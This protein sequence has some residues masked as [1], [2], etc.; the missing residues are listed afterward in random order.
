MKYQIVILDD[1]R[2]VCNSLRRILDE[3][4][5]EISTFTS[6]EEAESYLLQERPDLLLLDYKL[7]STN[8]IDFLKKIR[9]DLPDL[10]TIMITAHGSID[11]AVEA[12]RLGAFDFIQKNQEP[13]VVRFTVQRAL[14]AVKLH[15]EVEELREI[16]RRDQN[17][18]EIISQSAAMRELLEVSRE[19]ARTDST[20]LISGE[21]GT[22]KNLLALHLHLNSSRFNQPFIAVN[23]T[24][25]PHELLESELF[26]YEKG[27]FTGANQKGKKGLLEQANGGT[28]FLDEIGDMSL[29]LQ[30]KLLHILENNQFMRLGA[31]APTRVDVRFITATNADLE[32]K[33]A[34]GRFRM[35][36][37]YR[38]NVARLHLPPLRERR[39]DILPL[40]KHFIEQ[41]NQ[42]FDK[43]V[44]RISPEA[45]NYLL[46][47]QWPGNI[48]ELCNRVERAMLL[49]KGDTLTLEDLLPNGKQSPKQ[50]ADRQ[51]AFNIH[52]TPGNGAN[53][54]KEAQKQLIQ[55]A[56]AL[57]N[58]NRSKAARLLGIP[59][60]SLTFYL[61]KMEETD[62]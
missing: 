20:V 33:V 25:I 51:S 38:L 17:M 44:N 46:N 30:G 3:D 37:Y 31:V 48:R 59:R 50:V 27:A 49:K 21:T 5:R 52:L 53:L 24:A 35:D 60:T 16:Y 42:R 4:N 36:L 61:G 14:E 40:T 58:G 57:T 13:D 12:M 47:Y 62:D 26:G 39:E 55:Q 54:L 23:C 1:E 15:K 18:P 11:T 9:E 22:G 56:L 34:E 10:K 29:D 32:E 28:L 7:G 41:Y 8:G 45:E 43:A 6:P 19:I 2:L